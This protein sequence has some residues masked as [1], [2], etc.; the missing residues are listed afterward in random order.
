MDITKNQIAK[1]RDFAQEWER[2]NA[3][4]TLSAEWLATKAEEVGNL[5]DVFNGIDSLARKLYGMPPLTIKRED[6][7]PPEHLRF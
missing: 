4:G 3:H 7:N 5:I 1:A 2:R 6:E